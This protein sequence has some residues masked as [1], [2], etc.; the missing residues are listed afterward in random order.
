MDLLVEGSQLFQMLYSPYTNLCSYKDIIIIAQNHMTLPSTISPKETDQKEKPIDRE[1]LDLYSD[2]L[3]TSFSYT[4]AT[5]PSRVLDHSISHD[6]ITRFLSERTYSSK[7]LW[8][9][10]KPAVREMKQESDILIFDDTV[11]EKEYTD[12][13]DIMA[14]RFDHTVGRSRE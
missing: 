14:W 3:I 7:D 9:L 1:M 4:T 13:N 12:E 10:V 11:E 5:D 8:L 2:Y 6:K